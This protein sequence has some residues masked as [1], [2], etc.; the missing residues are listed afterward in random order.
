MS[1]TRRPLGTGPT[2]STKSTPR[3]SSR[4][5]RLAAERIEDEYQDVVA[6]ED[7]GGVRMLRGRRALGTGPA[8]TAGSSSSPA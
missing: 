8:G 7:Q 6:D 1:T 2:T 3:P 4:T 5:R